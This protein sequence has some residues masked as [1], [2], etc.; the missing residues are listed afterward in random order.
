MTP[1]G[2]VTTNANIETAIAG[3]EAIMDR[4]EQ[5]IAEETAQVRVGRLS[6]AFDLDEY[7]D[8]MRPPLPDGE[9]APED[10]QRS[11]RTGRVRSPTPPA[12]C[13]P[14]HA[15]HEPYRAG[16]GAR[17]V[18]RHHSRCV[19]RTCAQASSIDL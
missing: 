12:R 6:K 7:Q 17:G 14:R 8:R 4:L 13:F 1:A 19:R 11:T 5:A 18:R 15:A 16:N 2:S 9:R 3:L 10:S